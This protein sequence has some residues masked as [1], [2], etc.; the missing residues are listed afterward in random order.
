MTFHL[1]AT[2]SD[3][4]GHGTTG[5][6]PSSLRKA[7]S[8]RSPELIGARAAPT[9]YEQQQ[10]FGDFVSGAGPPS[11]LQRMSPPS[12]LAT[13]IVAIPPL[14]FSKCPHSSTAPQEGHHEWNTSRARIKSSSSLAE[15]STVTPA[16]A[17]PAHHQKLP[18][19]AGRGRRSGAARPLPCSR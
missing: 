13:L 5:A 12:T 17:Q 18:R 19:R 8:R 10:L 16:T 9:F 1:A 7:N 11:A 2:I 6:T 4:A 15:T 3:R 14:A